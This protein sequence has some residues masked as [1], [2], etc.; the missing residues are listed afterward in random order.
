MR[1][2][3]VGAVLMAL[4]ACNRD[5]PAE[6]ARQTEAPQATAEAKGQAGEVQ[7]NATAQKQAGISVSPAVAESISETISATG[8]L[9]HNEDQVWH[10][11]AITDGRVVAIYAKP[12]DFVK[13]GQVMARLHTHEVHESRAAFRKAMEEVDRA[14]AAEI[15]AR[16][17]RDRAQRLFDLKAASREQVDTA[18]NELRNAQAAVKQAR[19]ELEKERVHLVE[20]LEVPV[21]DPHAGKHPDHQEDYV[22]LKAPESGTVVTRTATPGSVVSRGDDVFTIT[23]TNTLWMIASVNEADLAFLRV[24]QPV[25][26]LVRAYPGRTFRGRILRVGEQLDPETRTL[27]VR[28]LVPNTGGLL[29]PEM[30]ASAEIEK[31]ATRQAVVVPEA[32]IQDV[33]GHRA[34]FVRTAANRFRVQLV[35]V[36]RSANGRAEI[37]NG[38]TPGTEVVVRGSFVLKSQ[39]LKSSLGEEE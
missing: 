19:T 31:A 24:G 15:H 21:E 16:R 39:L 30:Y 7:M 37:V 27:K 26:L 9:T 3:A 29:K 34:V 2:F 18:E 28:V 5:R 8:Q 33:N 11:G 35:D 22:P 23:N 12:G 20:F 17:V 13:A 6:K 36:A 38:L 14:Q 4:T 1:L 25:N 10:V 32:A